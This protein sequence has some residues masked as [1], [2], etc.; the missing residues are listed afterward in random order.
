M[1]IDVRIHFTGLCAYLRPETKDRF[2]VI[3]VDAR[4]PSDA[5][6]AAGMHPHV[7]TVAVSTTQLQDHPEDRQPDR[8]VPDTTGDVVAIFD[9]DFEELSIPTS[10]LLTVTD[11]ARPG[12]VPGT[13]PDDQKTLGWMAPLTKLNFNRDTLRSECTGDLS[14]RG[15]VVARMRLYGGTVTCG[16]VLQHDGAFARWHFSPT[17]SSPLTQ[18]LGDLV[19]VDMTIPSPKEV[20]GFKG[21]IFSNQRP[22]ITLE[23]F[24]GER[25]DVVVGNIIT[26]LEAQ[27]GQ[28]AIPHF[29]WYYELMRIPPDLGK[30]PLP[31]RENL[32]SKTTTRIICAQ[33]FID[34]QGGI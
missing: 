2:D 11:F 14:T 1:S 19:F 3:L 8:L 26:H 28:D 13:D 33:G 24:A 12:D 5:Q 27:S 9:L 7:P 31:L 17:P 18:A 23:P 21:H 25:V 10:T 30:R 15:A 32:G 6:H 4:T 22:P 20:E 34:K 16:R 29:G